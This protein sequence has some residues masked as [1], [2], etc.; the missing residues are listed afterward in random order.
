[1]T[2]YLLTVPQIIKMSKKVI[3]DTSAKKEKVNSIANRMAAA[4]DTS[5]SLK[6]RLDNGE[7]LSEEEIDDYIKAIKDEDEI[8]KELKDFIQ[9]YGV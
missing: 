6:R 2:Q 4:I 1:M 9:E 5:T 3:I 8:A 7:E